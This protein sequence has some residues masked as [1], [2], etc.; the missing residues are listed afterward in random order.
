MVDLSNRLVTTPKYSSSEINTSRSWY[1]KTQLYARKGRE[2]YT[3]YKNM[4]FSKFQ[5]FQNDK[6]KTRDRQ[7]IEHNKQFTNVSFLKAN[8]PIQADG[9]IYVEQRTK[10]RRGQYIHTNVVKAYTPEQYSTQARTLGNTFIISHRPLTLKSATY[11][12]KRLTQQIQKYKERKAIPVQPKARPSYVTTYADQQAKA[13]LEK[14]KPVKWTELS[15][16]SKL[17]LRARDTKGITY[18]EKITYASAIKEQNQIKAAIAKEKLID[19]IAKKFAPKGIDI[20]KQM[21][22]PGKILVP[23]KYA[24]ANQNQIWN[25]EKN[26]VK[27]KLQQTNTRITEINKIIRNPILSKNYRDQLKTELSQLSNSKIALD[28]QAKGLIKELKPL[29]FKPMAKILESKLKTIGVAKQKKLILTKKGRVVQTI[30]TTK[31][32]SQLRN[33]LKEQPQT[34]QVQQAISLI[35]KTDLAMTNKALAIAPKILKD[36]II[37]ALKQRAA[38][39]KFVEKA[40]VWTD[41]K[42]SKT[43]KDISLMGKREEYN[44][45]LLN[46]KFSQAVMR[47]A[48]T[49]EKRLSKLG[50]VMDWKGSR[51]LA[52]IP[53]MYAK[54]T[55]LYLLGVTKLGVDTA[56]FIVNPVP[57]VKGLYKLGG[58]IAKVNFITPLL[59]YDSL[60]RK[61][62]KK[63]VLSK[64]LKL[65]QKKSK[66]NLVSI[67]K[68][69]LEDFNFLLNTGFFNIFLE[70]LS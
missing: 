36:V 46:R 56:K 59:V 47:E 66:D 41:A 55:T 64:K 23:L 51:E 26:T 52:K 3:H 21:G 6:E 44:S 18:K 35:D 8:V 19:N 14:A 60:S 4:S 10:N 37:K 65:T 2:G 7:N 29:E 28:L 16:M 9:R 48:T 45:A 42:V 63:P 15:E 24:I 38:A 12:D 67:A 58:D 57:V 30:A 43:I 40:S 20:G 17:N 33:Y 49:K 22:A 32:A 68:Y 13:K 27:S 1:K 69:M 61:I 54:V 5:T 50:Y 39:R 34:K 11:K 62:L 70:R 25:R 31:E 53:Q